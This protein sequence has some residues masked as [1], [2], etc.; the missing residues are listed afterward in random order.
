LLHRRITRQ[1]H[2]GFRSNKHPLRLLQPPT[3]RWA[4]LIAALSLFAILAL[5][6]R[7]SAA[8]GGGPS[9]CVLCGERGS[10]DLILNILLFI[11]LGAALGRL[12][13]RPIIAAGLGLL[14]ALGIEV[15][16]VLI[17][18][19]SPTWRDVILNAIGMGLGA[20][21]VRDAL[22][23]LSSR[24]ASMFAYIAAALAGLCVAA[25]GWFLEPQVKRN[26]WY[27]HINPRLGHLAIW[28]GRVTQVRIGTL[29]QSHGMVNDAPA[30]QSAVQ[31]REPIVIEGIA[32]TAPARLAGLYSISDDE[33]EEML[34]VGIEGS[35]LV[36]RE[37]RRASAFRL[38]EPEMRVPGFF[39]EIIVGQPFV[40]S[41][42]LDARLVCASINDAPERCSAP[43]AASS[44]WTLVLWR[45]WLGSDG[46]VLL[47]ALTMLAMAIPVGLLASRASWRTR[48]SLGVAVV[49]SVYLGAYAS[50]L[51]R[52]TVTELSALAAGF[53]LGLPWGQRLSRL[54]SA[55]S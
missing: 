36:V 18:G 16:Q 53:A 11:P 3:S 27:A 14:L 17:P 33:Y 41:V 21:L 38:F 12:G 37:R 8:G 50:G 26:V 32:G 6:L 45:R 28:D 42:R 25:T 55:E 30:L 54:A 15:A 4:R 10:A 24:R 29:S 48:A 5:T 1:M 43:F 49:A 51:A 7:P 22:R 35:N 9:T 20:W 39:G 19:R 47:G 44:G 31:A 40:L 52:P 46:R 23:L 13:W 2:S 34:L